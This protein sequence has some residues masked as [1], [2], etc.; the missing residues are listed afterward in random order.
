[1]HDIE[2][3]MFEV[4]EASAGEYEYGETELGEHELGEDEYEYEYGEVGEAANELTLATELLEVGSEA[5]L[6]QFIGSLLSTAVGAA[7][8]FAK[9]DTGRQ[10]GGILKQAAKRALPVVGR[11]IGAAIDPRF[12]APGARAAQAVGS[13]F[14]L[15]LEGLSHE[16]REFETARAFVRFGTEAARRAAAAPPN[17]PPPAVARA[18][19]AT[20]ATR[21]APGLVRWLG[22]PPG[23]G[24]GRRGRW[25]R[26]GSSIVLFG[27]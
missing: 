18:A 3:A 25:V 8:R 20:A 7:K 4:G 2:R 9:S 6:E 12:A 19:A 11:G 22:P 14:G 15:E 21:Y 13:I 10:L 5:E 17:A 1:M 24:S 27:V 16:D 23:P 26:R